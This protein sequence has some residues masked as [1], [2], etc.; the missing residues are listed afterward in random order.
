[1]EV[2]ESALNESLLGSQGVYKQGLPVTIFLAVRLFSPQGIFPSRCQDAEDFCFRSIVFVLFEFILVA[3]AKQLPEHG[4]KGPH[5]ATA[6]YMCDDLFKNML[7]EIF[8]FRLRPDD[9]V[10]F[11][12][13]VTG[14]KSIFPILG[15]TDDPAVCI[16]RDLV[17]V[18]KELLLR[19][20]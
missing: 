12:Y 10:I 18:V 20:P 11:W 14:D 16:E 4:V 8:V 19:N 17:D 13:V 3:Y 2:V 6:A 7:P 15:Q 5:A 1:M 9:S